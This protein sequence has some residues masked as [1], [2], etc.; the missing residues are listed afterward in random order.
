MGM[1]PK[2]ML[3]MSELGTDAWCKVV[4]DRKNEN[5]KKQTRGEGNKREEP[6]TRRTRIEEGMVQ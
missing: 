4:Y 6:R 1:C 3:L 2:E 5:E